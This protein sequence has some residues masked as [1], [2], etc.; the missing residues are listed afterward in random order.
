[1][2]AP[3]KSRA[4]AATRRTPAADRA[5]GQLTVLKVGGE[6]LEND[7]KRTAMGRAVARLARKGPLV[8][9]HGGGRDIDAALAHAGISRRQVDGLRVTDQATLDVVVGVLAGGINTKFVAAVNAAGGRAVGLT[10]AD[11][12]VGPVRKAPPHRAASGEIVDLG[13]VGEPIAARS[14]VVLETLRQAAVVP[15]IA[16][17]G[18]SRDGRLFNVN[19]DTLAGSLAA[20]LN[21]ARLVIAGGTAGVLDAQGGTIPA[22]SARDATALVRSGAASAGMVA[23]LAA[24]RAAIAGGV[25]EVLIADGRDPARLLDRPVGTQVTK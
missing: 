17:I 5:T 25:R 1:V 14:P 12:G 19:A 7:A 9:V 6:L 10:G 8:V 15:I 20:R 2:T 4:R 22:L 21:A 16:C 24:C 11:A 3:R 13:L 23:K 18:A